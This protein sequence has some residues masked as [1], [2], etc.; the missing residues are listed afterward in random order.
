MKNQLS[1][2]NELFE[3]VST[4]LGDSIPISPQRLVIETGSFKESVK[5]K[6]DKK[7]ATPVGK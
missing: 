7:Q 5:E 2:L 4:I 6:N 1:V 3:S